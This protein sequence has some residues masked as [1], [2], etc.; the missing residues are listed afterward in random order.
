MYIYI[1]NIYV[2]SYIM[3]T[4]CISMHILSSHHVRHLPQSH[5]PQRRLQ[6]LLAIHPGC[7]VTPETPSSGPTR[8]N[9]VLRK[10]RD[11]D[12]LSHH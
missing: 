10:N 11:M 4:S 6:S 3:Y 9:S 12:H 8:T 7:L 5:L 2:L 1:Y